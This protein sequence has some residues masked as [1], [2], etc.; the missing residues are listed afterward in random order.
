[1]L[2]FVIALLFGAVLALPILFSLK[3]DETLGHKVTWVEIWTPMWIVD[4]FMGLLAVMIFCSHRSDD[5]DRYSEDEDTA[6]REKEIS[7]S[8]KVINLVQTVLFISLQVLILTK[9]DGS[10]SISWLKTLSPWIGYECV[11]VLVSLPTALLSL[12]DRQL[13]GEQAVSTGDDEQD[14]LLSSYLRESECLIR[15]V[16]RF[17]ARHTIFNSV[18]RIWQAVFLAMELDITVS[19]NWA[20]VLL[21]LWLLLIGS[22]Y[23]AFSLRDWGDAVVD[24]IASE[25]F[26]TEEQQSLKAQASTA[27]KGYASSLCCVQ[28]LGSI[29]SVL[30]ILR[31][32]DI[33]S[34][35]AFIIL[36]PVFVVIGC[37]CCAVYATLCAYAVV[38]PDE[39]PIEAESYGTFG[40]S[41]AS[42]NISN[43]NI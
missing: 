7:T 8:A 37:C 27:I 36:L 24:E 15:A 41:E 1:M 11:T 34:Y 25:A 32:E 13:A 20:F 35:S 4:G 2:M 29:I 5:E 43:N 3:V 42:S 9:L 6:A 33:A 28:V 26:V 21:P 40:R 19:W 14:T 22:A 10:I 38:D 31:L 23:I 17:K 16:E 39:I 12:N 30:L 18:L